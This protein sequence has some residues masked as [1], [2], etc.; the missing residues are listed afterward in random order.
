MA[1]QVRMDA[2]AR[3][4]VQRHLSRVLLLLELAAQELRRASVL[5][6][7]PTVFDEYLSGADA[8]IEAA[9]QKALE[10]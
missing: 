7:D 4:R 1:G 6:P 2:A 8:L 3:A 9:R 5:A 10:F